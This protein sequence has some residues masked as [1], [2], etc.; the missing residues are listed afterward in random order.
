M[1]EKRE[2][3]SDEAQ[4]IK[5]QLY[6]LRCQILLYDTDRR[7]FFARVDNGISFWSAM[8]L[9]FVWLRK[10]I[11]KNN[12]WCALCRLLCLNF[13][14]HPKLNSYPTCFVSPSDYCVSATQHLYTYSSIASSHAWMKANWWAFSY[15]RYIDGQQHAKGI[16][17][18]SI[19]VFTRLQCMSTKLTTH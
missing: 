9:L 17:V 6:W 7:Y 16:Q 5:Q 12:W 13:S 3:R 18:N 1:R 19:Q 4:K 2:K 14:F 11:V 15:C 8:S 10:M